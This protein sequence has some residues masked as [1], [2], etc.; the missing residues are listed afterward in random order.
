MRETFFS[1]EVRPGLLAVLLS[2]IRAGFVVD[3]LWDAALG[4]AGWLPRRASR[5]RCASRL[6]LSCSRSGRAWGAASRLP[7]RRPSQQRSSQRRCVAVAA[8]RQ[9]A[10]T[11]AS[12]LPPSRAP[13]QTPLAFWERIKAG[14]MGDLKAVMGRWTRNELWVPPRQDQAFQQARP[15]AVPGSTGW[16]RT[17]GAASLRR[18]AAAPPCLLA[19]AA[20]PTSARRQPALLLGSAW[21]LPSARADASHRS[22]WLRFPPPPCRRS[23]A[24]RRGRV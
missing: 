10:L 9:A 18:C 15:A 23:H 21:A 8:R 7:E 12:C 6:S 13:P 16:H 17:T 4:T 22:P 14:R 2:W 5:W 24:G 3:L 19:C 20:L 11:P 1:A